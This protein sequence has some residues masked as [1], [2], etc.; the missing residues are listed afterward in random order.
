MGGV[1]GEEVKR[2]FVISVTRVIDSSD[3]DDA[4]HE[5]RSTRRPPPTLPRVT[6][7]Q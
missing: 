7:A 4:K 3:E 2:P 5:E 6:A 1:R